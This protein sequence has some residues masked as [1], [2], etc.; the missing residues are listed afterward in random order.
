MHLK[1][2]ISVQH[3]AREDHREQWLDPRRAAAI[4]LMVPVGAMVVTVAL[5]RRLARLLI[6]RALPVR[7]WRRAPV[8]AVATPRGLVTHKL[9]DLL[10]GAHALL[11]I[12]GMPS[13]ISMSA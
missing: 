11:A 1:Q 13:R 9:H 12:V 5:Q 3:V 8:R 10:G 4:M 6:G 2:L 7:E